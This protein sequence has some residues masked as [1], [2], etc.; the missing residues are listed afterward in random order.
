MAAVCIFHFQLSKSNTCTAV[1]F[2]ILRTGQNRFVFCSI[3]KSI[4]ALHIAA[5]AK[6]AFAHLSVF[7]FD[8]VAAYRHFIIGILHIQAMPVTT[9]VPVEQVLFFPFSIGHHFGTYVVLTYIQCA[10]IQR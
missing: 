8:E 9:S 3:I 5:N 1:D 10:A 2:L 7:T 4:V 6:H